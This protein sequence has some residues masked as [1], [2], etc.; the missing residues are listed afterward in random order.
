MN[1]KRLFIGLVL[2]GALS[3][4][5][6]SPAAN[7]ALPAESV[8]T[9]YG[10]IGWA[11]YPD[12]GCEGTTGGGEGRTVRATTM[13]ELCRY[14]GAEEPLVILL[15]GKFT[16]H[17]RVQVASD[18]TLVGVG[19]GASFE[20][21]CFETNGC[22]NII[23][24]NLKIT[25]GSPDGIS[26]RNTHH[27]WVDHCDLSD[28]GDGLLDFT[29]GSSY[30]TV[31]WTRLHHHNKV[32]LANSGTG[33]FEDVGRERVTYHHNWFYEGVQRNPRVGYG[34]GHVFNNY[35]SDI[36]S[37]CIGFFC[38]AKVLAQNNY[39]FRSQNP[40][41]QMYSDVPGSAYYGSCY[42]ENNIFDQC[43]GTVTAADNAFRPEDY[44]GYSFCLQD[45]K[46][47]PDEVQALSGP[48]T[49]IGAEV[50]PLPG[51]GALAVAGNHLHWT[52]LEGAVSWKLRYGTSEKDMKEVRLNQRD[53]FPQL[54]PG[55]D[56]LWQ[57]EALMADGSKQISPLWHFRTASALA[58]QPFPAN[59]DQQAILRGALSR[60][61]TSLLPLSWNPAWKAVA[62]RVYLGETPSLKEENLL[63]ETPSTQCRLRQAI[64]GKTLYWRVDA[65]DIQGNVTKGSV[66]SFAPADCPLQEGVCPSVQLV[67]GGQ[68][69]LEKPEKESLRAA[70]GDWAVSGD[71]GPGCVS[72][73]WA[74]QEGDY[75]LTLNYFDEND[76]QA[77]YS[78]FVAGKQVDTW[79]SDADSEALESHTTAPLHLSGGDEILIEFMPRR[80]EQCRMASLEIR[81]VGLK[82]AK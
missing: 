70:L 2:S 66:W 80:G 25:K 19:E 62:Y 49:G 52:R 64:S 4:P 18:K 58:S 68:A 29:I 7:A 41:R 47:L 51:N 28:S 60:E 27:V 24:R 76:G 31:S 35:Y 75:S 45:P 44:Y 59:G 79:R 55:T 72:G 13:E 14:A 21:V 67:R 20:N 39:F 43:Q 9:A 82:S 23:M 57:V 15:E 77:S 61:R 5:L 50:M 30:M 73:R 54:R 69:F 53:Y 34:L 48:Q 65:V 78:L 38:G 16:D 17:V 32:S 81:N 11:C 33:H 74:G 8:S 6:I 40:F 56:Y 10:L 71:A 26:F 36:P 22:H 46:L 1:M 63:M 37:Y 12:M 3:V 42:S